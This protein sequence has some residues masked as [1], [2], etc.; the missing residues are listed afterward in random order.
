MSIFDF[1]V[2]IKGSFVASLLLFPILILSWVLS[3]QLHEKRRRKS[4]IFL[5][6]I[7]LG[8]LTFNGISLIFSL[9]ASSIGIESFAISSFFNIIVKSTFIIFLY[10]FYR[11][12]NK[13]NFKLQLIFIVPTIIVILSGLFVPVMGYIIAI[14]SI[15]T[16]NILYGNKLGRGK[17]IYIAS[18][19]FVVSLLI[20]IVI[21]IAP[22]L[23]GS[24]YMLNIL[25]EVS[26]YTLLLVNLIEHSLIIMQSS[27]V[28]AITDSLTGLFNR[29]YFTKYINGCV[30]RSI[31]VNVIFCDIDNFKNLNDTKGHKVGDEVLKQ[32]AT[33]FREEVEGI[34]VAGRYGGEEM[35][36]LI[37][38]LDVDMEELTERMRS[39][40]EKETITT[41]SIGYRLYDP[42]VPADLL[43]KQADEA[44][45]EAKAA[46]KNRV[47]SYKLKA[48]NTL[49]LAA[50]E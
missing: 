49:N 15:V 13:E 35:V 43:I 28:S 34:G 23:H 17:S 47:M 50:N 31:P 5:S 10:G 33:I 14:L 41:A 26:S 21:G 37:Q 11:I 44:M 4:Y 24:L 3:R 12:H 29:R 39:R 32:V 30:D 7:T 18:G 8:Y 38:S 27:Y 48:V 42:S 36:L 46:G 6:K 20:S 9:V 2:G 40:I 1:F 16:M 19:L 45:Y 22:S 25:L